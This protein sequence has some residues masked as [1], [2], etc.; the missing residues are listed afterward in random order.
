MYK[1]ATAVAS[2]GG[3]SDD[4]TGEGS[5]GP[6]QAKGQG[7]RANRVVMQ[8][9]QG[10]CCMHM[11]LKQVSWQCFCLQCSVLLLHIRMTE[12]YGDD[13]HNCECV[14]T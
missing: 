8:L 9:V 12:L 3:S 11:S 13:A 6:S 7:D 2:T 4:K 10:R 14:C 1:P 5:R